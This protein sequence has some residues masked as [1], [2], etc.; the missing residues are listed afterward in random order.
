[1]GSRINA[2]AEVVHKRT[3]DLMQGLLIKIRYSTT[4]KMLGDC[5][6]I[7]LFHSFSLL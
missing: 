4:D 1:M 7:A 5:T 3:A 2:A 6:K